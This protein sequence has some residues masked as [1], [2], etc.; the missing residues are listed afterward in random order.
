MELTKIAIQAL[1]RAIPLTAENFAVDDQRA[2]IIEGLF[3]AA[4]MEEPDVQ[5]VAL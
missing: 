1:S 2:F 5:E 4:E 3:K